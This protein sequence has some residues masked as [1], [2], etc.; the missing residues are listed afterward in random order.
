MLICQ[1]R[2]GTLQ[3][4]ESVQ[5]CN[6]ASIA[7]AL[8]TDKA[9]PCL[10]RAH[11]LVGREGLEHITKRVKPQVVAVLIPCMSGKVWNEDGIV[12]KGLA[13]S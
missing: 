8:R 4:R 10:I 1:G 11:P 9:V 12:A 5:R 6:C 2:F 7:L 13:E 3:R